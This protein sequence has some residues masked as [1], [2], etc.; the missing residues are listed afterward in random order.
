MLALVSDRL[1]FDGFECFRVRDV[2]DVSLD[3]YAGFAEAALRK[4]GQRK[5]R[6]PAV[7]LSSSGALLLSA[8]RRFPLVAIHR[9]QIDPEVCWIG[10]LLGVHR[11]RLSPL[12]IYPDT[13]WDTTPTEYPVREIT[14]I[15]FGGDYEDALA[16]VGGEPHPIRTLARN[17]VSH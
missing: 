6:K 3:P 16:S 13:K 12:E 1:W 7:D 4:R 17:S 9:E 8:G 10:R 14:H 2:L 15:N 5:P 11:G